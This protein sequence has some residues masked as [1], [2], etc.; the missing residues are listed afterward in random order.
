MQEGKTPLMYAVEYTTSLA[1]LEVLLEAKAEVNAKDYV[2]AW[3]G[4]R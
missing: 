3:E 1:V 4:D 2:S